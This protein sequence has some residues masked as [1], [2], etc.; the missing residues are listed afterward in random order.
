MK[1]SVLFLLCFMAFSACKKQ[2]EEPETANPNPDEVV[3][4]LKDNSGFDTV[5]NVVKGLSSATFAPPSIQIADFSVETNNNF[6]IVYYTEAPSQ[7]SVLA[8]YFRFSKNLTTQAV[9]PLPPYADNLQ[10]LSPA[11]IANDGLGLG[12]QQFKPYSNYFTY[13]VSR[14]SAS[15]NFKNS[16]EFKGDISCPISTFNPI[17]VADMGYYYPVSNIGGTQ[18]VDNAFGYFTLGTPNASYLTKVCNSYSIVFLNKS[19]YRIIRSLIE[20]RQLAQGASMVFT[21]RPD[22]VVA[23]EFNYTTSVLST[24]TR[25]KL[26]S[27]PLSG[28]FQTLRHYSAD[29]KIM[30]IMLKDETLNKYWTFSYNFTTKVL[31]KGLENATLEYSADG[32]D[33]DLD[34]FGNIYYSGYAANG[35]NKAGVS[36]YKKA[37]DAQTTRIGADDFLK[38]GTIIQLKVLM[39]KVY[40]ALNGK[41]TGFEKYQ[42]SVLKQK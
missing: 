2:T 1:N 36:I 29:G 27:V 40:F 22:S 37:I 14:S 26:E 23:S 28:S 31:A 25:L 35:S 39:G 33:L 6:N 12:L 20:P 24:V 21:I 30:G 8:N 15:I 41:K 10:T 38:F 11:Q 7:Q 17:G 18:N 5:F 19:G 9:I 34:E 3:N 32:T 4:V 13:V 16:I 42:L